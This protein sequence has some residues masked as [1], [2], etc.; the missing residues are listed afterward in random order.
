M[1]LP[2]RKVRMCRSQMWKEEVSKAVIE[3]TAKAAEAE[4]K[5]YGVVINS[6][7]ELEGDYAEHYRKVMGRRAWSIGLVSLWRL[8]TSLLISVCARLNCNLNLTINLCYIT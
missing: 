1:G 2:D 6:F 7:N 5:S 4:E 3:L 8:V